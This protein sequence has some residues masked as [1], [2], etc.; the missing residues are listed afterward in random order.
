MLDLFFDDKFDLVLKNGDLSTDSSLRMA[1]SMSL[2]TDRR[3]E[4]TDRL[5][6]NY[7]DP[8]GYVGDAIDNERVG[9]RIWL[10]EDE[11]NTQDARTRAQAYALESLQWLVNDGFAQKIDVSAT[12]NCDRIDLN[13]SICRQDG[14]FFNELFS[15]Q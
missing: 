10:L 2:F 14:T 4:K 6:C 7:T 8:R 12:Q 15:V 1:I 9:S 5:P 11:N 13:V 3:A